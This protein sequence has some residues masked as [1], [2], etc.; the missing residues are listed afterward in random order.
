MTDSIASWITLSALIASV[1]WYIHQSSDRNIN[2]IMMC[3]ASGILCL[4]GGFLISGL[5][6]KITGSFDSALIPALLVCVGTAACTVGHAVYI[7]KKAL[8]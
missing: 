3:I 4:F 7:K 1:G 2:N 6:M 5:I 8:N